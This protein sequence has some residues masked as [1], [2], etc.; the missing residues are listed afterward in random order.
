M[1]PAETPPTASPASEAY[2]SQAGHYDRRTDAFRQWRE[3][4]VASLPLRPGDTVLDVGCGT[5]L[6]APLLHRQVGPAG[7]IIGIDESEQMLAVAA[8]RVTEHGWDNV[9]L[10]AAPVATAPIDGMA[11]AALFC[12]VH[13]IMQSRAALDNIVAHLRPGSPVGATGGK[14]PAP[15]MWPLR[16]WVTRLHR[17]FIT[18]FTGFDRPWRLL[19]KYVPDLQVR[20]LACT[21]GYLAVGHTPGVRQVQLIS[22]RAAD[23]PGDASRA[24]RSPL[25]ATPGTAPARPGGMPPA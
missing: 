7:T 23:G 11:D 25:P 15:W 22:H 14:Q 16:P 17:P 12:A 13:D 5:G 4:L 24:R 10:I 18:D 8:H 1:T 3:L 6:C 21:G 20:E 2:R 19:A 9:R